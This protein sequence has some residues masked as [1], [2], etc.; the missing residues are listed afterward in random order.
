MLPLDDVDQQLPR[1]S[2]SG[3]DDRR[4]NQRLTDCACGGRNSAVDGEYKTRPL[5]GR[6]SEASGHE[7]DGSGAPDPCRQGLG[8]ERRP[9]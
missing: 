5:T 2:Q 1:G 7:L 3:F 8:A 4:S 6:W 9:T